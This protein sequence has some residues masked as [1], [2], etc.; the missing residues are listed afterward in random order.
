M[1][2]D[3][4]SELEPTQDNLELQSIDSD[5]ESAIWWI[6]AFTCILQTLH[7]LPLQSVEFLLKFLTCLLTFLGKYSIKIAEIANVLSCSLHTRAKY[8]EKYLFIAPVITRVVCVRCHT[9]Y[10]YSE[11]TEVREHIVYVKHCTTCKCRNPLL[12]EIVT[13]TGNKRFYPYSIYPY[14]SLIETLKTFFRRPG[15]TELCGK[16]QENVDLKSSTFSDIY[17]GRICKEFMYYQGK[18]FLSS[19]N[20]LAVMMNIDWY[21]PYKHR[22]YSVGVI[23][24]VLMNLPR[25]IWF[26]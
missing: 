11:C 16:W 23:Y 19:R 10:K 17:S 12:R 2:S 20:N 7:S 22:T 24:L 25:N 18:E 13:S 26:K 5:Q 8:L 14:C 3:C 6:V 4:D 15:F 21:Q 9:L 1:K